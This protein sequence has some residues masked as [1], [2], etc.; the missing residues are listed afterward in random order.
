MSM[1]GGLQAKGF[2]HGCPGRKN[3]WLHWMNLNDIES[4]RLFPTLFWTNLSGSSFKFVRMICIKMPPKKQI[5]LFHNGK[6][7]D[8]ARPKAG[9]LNMEEETKNNSK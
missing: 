3:Y 8:R 2:E 9:L 7:L 1:S 5:L 4:F 6:S